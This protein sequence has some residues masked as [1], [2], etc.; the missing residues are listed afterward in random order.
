MPLRALAL[1]VLAA[2]LFAGEKPVAGPP[3]KMDY[4][5]ARQEA[6]AAG[7]P[8]FLYFTKTY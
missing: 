6:L 8:L 7:K 3:W 2:P 1:L 5:E 4:P